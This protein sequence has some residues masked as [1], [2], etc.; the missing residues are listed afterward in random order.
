MSPRTGVLI[1]NILRQIKGIISLTEQ[2]IKA[3][4]KLGTVGVSGNT[5]ETSAETS[6]T[7]QRS[8]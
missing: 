5:S 3:E 1:L 8:S 2:Y 4:A 7:V 6:S